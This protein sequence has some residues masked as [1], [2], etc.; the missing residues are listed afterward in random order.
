MRGFNKI[1]LVTIINQELYSYT[2]LYTIAIKIR[3][4]TYLQKYK[5]FET[6]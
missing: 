5:P 6:Y 1:R 4:Y 3:K 2:E